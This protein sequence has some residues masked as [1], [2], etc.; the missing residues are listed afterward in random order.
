MIAHHRL[1]GDT[2]QPEVFQRLE[3]IRSR[4]YT[5]AGG[6]PMRILSTCVDSGFRKNEVYTYV[7]SV[8]HLGVHAVK[9]DDGAKRDPVSRSKSK[10]RAGI[11]LVIVGTYAMK[12]TL[13]ARLKKENL[14]PG[15][16]H[17]R[18][19]EPDWHNGAD[20]EYFAQFARE[21]KQ[22][23]RIGN[24]YVDEY[25]KTGPNEAIDLGVYNLAALHI[26]GPSVRETLD[27]YAR[28]VQEEGAELRARA[29]EPAA[30]EPDPEPPSQRRRSSWAYG[31]Q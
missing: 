2:S 3:A 10:N 26:L 28:Q 25:V 16:M 11:K 22:R 24:R 5:H 14:G 6:A 8:Q 12:D 23:R 7:A 29:S 15:Y 18:A 19:M 31:F 30:A 4:I 9:G 21:R 27:A 17:F 1:V 20:A 13:F